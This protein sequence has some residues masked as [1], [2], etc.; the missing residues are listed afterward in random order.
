LR[1]HG[2]KLA[3]VS[4]LVIL[5]LLVLPPVGVSDISSGAVAYYK[6]QEG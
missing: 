3:L 5:S 2:M 4:V 6:M 1:K